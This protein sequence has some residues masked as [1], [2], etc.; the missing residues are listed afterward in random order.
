[1]IWAGLAV[2]AFAAGG[3]LAFLSIRSMGAPALDLSQSK[4]APPLQPLKLE[5][6]TPRA[7]AVKPSEETIPRQVRLE[8]LPLE[9]PKRR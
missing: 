7:E 2:A 6:A 8:E 1:L 3:L 5:G 9:R 4:A